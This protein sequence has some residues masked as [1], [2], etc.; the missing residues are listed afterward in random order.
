MYNFKEE[1]EE[2][3]DK[4]NQKEQ[5]IKNKILLPIFSICYGSYAIYFVFTLKKE[6]TSIIP[7]DSTNPLI[8]FFSVHNYV[9]TLSKITLYSGGTEVVKI[10]VFSM[11]MTYIY[12]KMMRKMA[13]CHN[14]HYQKLKNQLYCYGILSLLLYVSMMCDYLIFF[15]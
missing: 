12:I 4:F 7:N 10:I 13:Y 6:I 5:Y 14:F 9:Y 3:I 2:T 11:I 15:D 1:L 8:N